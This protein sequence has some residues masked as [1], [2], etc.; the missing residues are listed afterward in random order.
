MS[1][2]IATDN[3]NTTHEFADEDDA[4]AAFIAKF[5]IQPQQILDVTHGWNEAI[6]IWEDWESED[7]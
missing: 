2:Y 5:K 4:Y 1:K 3:V 7:E 6:V